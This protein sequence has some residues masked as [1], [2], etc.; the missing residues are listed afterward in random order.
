MRIQTHVT[1]KQSKRESTKL[2]VNLRIDERR[3]KYQG[4]VQFVKNI[5]TAESNQ[6]TNVYAR[7]NIVLFHPPDP[8]VF[9]VTE[10]LSL[11]QI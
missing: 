8:F 9:T 2:R 3:E 1:Q 10:K 7:R 11:F 5:F 6:P 4:N